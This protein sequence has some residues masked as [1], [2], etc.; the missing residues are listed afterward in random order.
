[1]QNLIK[2][3]E[4]PRSNID[5]Q[6]IGPSNL[7]RRA[8]NAI[9]QL[10]LVLSNSDSHLNTLRKEIVSLTGERDDLIKKLDSYRST[11]NDLSSSDTPSNT[12]SV[13]DE[14]PEVSST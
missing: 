1:M 3:L 2:Q 8:A 10:L 4:T 7:D 6:M 14:R 11:N 13:H 12:S 9:K 5:G